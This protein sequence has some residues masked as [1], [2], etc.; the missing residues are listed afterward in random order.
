M[1]VLA[2]APNVRRVRCR[3]ERCEVRLDAAKM[4]RLLQVPAGAWAV[5]NGTHLRGPEHRG[6][7]GVDG[8]EAEGLEAW[9]E[10]PGLPV[11]L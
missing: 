4:K 9:P 7:H 1:H 5:F 6:A 8:Q 10:P 3:L 11:F 2:S